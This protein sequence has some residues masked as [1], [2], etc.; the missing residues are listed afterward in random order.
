MTGLATAGFE[1]VAERAIEKVGLEVKPK[2]SPRERLEPNPK[3][4]ADVFAGEVLGRTLSIVRELLL[5]VV[6][7]AKLNVGVKEV[8]EPIGPEQ[9]A[10]NFVASSTK[11]VS[12]E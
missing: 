9:I 3:V 12:V 11:T 7:Y 6:L 10:D 8:Q 5:V 2:K 1:P 4:I